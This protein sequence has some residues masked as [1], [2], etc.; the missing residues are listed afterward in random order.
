M[1]QDDK[2]NAKKVRLTNIVVV[3]IM[4]ILGFMG[5]LALIS[6][7]LGLLAGLVNFIMMIIYIID[8]QTYSYI[9]CIISMLL[10]PIIGFGCCAMGVDGMNI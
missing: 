2:M 8:R 7:F 6:F 4:A 10:L 1:E 3:V 5:D 9:T